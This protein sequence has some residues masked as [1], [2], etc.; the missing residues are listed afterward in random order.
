MTD[1]LPPRE[2][3]P[4]D[5]SQ[6]EPEPEP[7]SQRVHVVEPPAG[8]RRR[9]PLPL[10]FGIGFI[11]LLAAVFYLWKHPLG[12]HLFPDQSR[13]ENAAPLAEQAASVAQLA[14]VD[15]QVK[16]AQQQ[17]AVLRQQTAAAQQDAIAARTEA[18]NA[19]RE[20]QAARQQAQLRGQQDATLA[21]RVE[22]LE[23][24]PV[25]AVP[26]LA[27]LNARIAALE[28]QAAEPPKQAPLPAEIATLPPRLATLSQRFDAL[29]A[30]LDQ[31]AGRQE[32]LSTQYQQLVQE[33]QKLAA[34][35]ASAG[36]A[37][38]RQID[39]ME[40]K[41]AAISEQARRL[42]GLADQ[43]GRVA[44]I[45]AAEAALDAGLPIGELPGAPPALARF[46]AAP[47]PTVAQLRLAF[48]AAAQAA[49]A[50]AQPASSNRS[51][52]NSVKGR[53]E[54]LVT[55]RRGDQVLVGNPVETIIANASTALDAG[56][57]GGAVADIAELKGPP[58][59]VFADW[60]AKAS[61]LLDARK[62]LAALAAQ[63]ALPAAHP[64]GQPVRTRT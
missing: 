62:A 27:P 59:Q 56:D 1:A 5:P 21:H 10:L 26:D 6:F 12:Q 31:I 28:K 32:Q 33:Q 14:A 51:F 54:S 8:R 55:V 47:P 9:D 46:A 15:A 40:A 4:S 64:A 35:A 43:S 53:V 23:R 39:A 2:E 48:P 13:T 25:P 41:V 38:A 50:A 58:A 63:S 61:A 18:Q 52:W 3:Q 36:A 17:L 7:G 30:R 11:V 44:R 29:A 57:L 37:T 45:Q 16:A 60:K 49:A 34:E 20:V 24:R 22:A 42:S 19:A